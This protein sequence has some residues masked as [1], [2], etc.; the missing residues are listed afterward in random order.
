M[1]YKK[2]YDKLI[3]RGRTRGLDKS[4]LD[5]YTEKHHAVPKCMGGS[6]DNSNLVLLTAREHYI[7]HL[8]LAILHPEIHGLS[9]AVFF[10]TNNPASSD[11]NFKIAKNSRIFEELRINIANSKRGKTTSD[12]QKEIVRKFFTEHNPSSE[13]DTTSLNNSNAKPVMDSE[14][15]IY[16][17]TK[18]CAKAL[19]HDVETIRYWC[20]DGKN[21]FKYI[22]REEAISILGIDTSS[23][24]KEKIKYALLRNYIQRL[25]CITSSNGR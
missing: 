15:N 8:I 21:G 25:V 20:R 3:E 1:D 12:K 7:C 17:T 16:P 23:K 6:N 5:Y 2:I 14:R 11:I 18:A 19:G 13:R 9:C 24:P 10:M 22:S 4:K